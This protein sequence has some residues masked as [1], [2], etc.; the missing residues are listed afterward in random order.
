MLEK[1]TKIFLMCLFFS[2]KKNTKRM[3]TLGISTTPLVDYILL[4]VGFRQYMALSMLRVIRDA[5]TP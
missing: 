1:A 3:Q 2:K 4:Y 5:S